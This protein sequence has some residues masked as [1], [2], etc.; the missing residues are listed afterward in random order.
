MYSLGI[1]NIENRRPQQIIGGSYVRSLLVLT[2]STVLYVRYVYSV[3]I[4]Y[5]RTI[6]TNTCTVRA[7]ACT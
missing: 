1:S 4:K 7:P 5:V 3:F 6:C 2:T